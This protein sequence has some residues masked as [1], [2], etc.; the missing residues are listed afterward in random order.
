MSNPTSMRRTRIALTLIVLVLVGLG[1]RRMLSDAAHDDDADAHSGPPH[2]TIGPDLG[3]A[4]GAAKK[5]RSGKIGIA[6]DDAD[7]TVAITGQVIDVIDHTPVPN[8]EVVFKSSVGESSGTTGPDGKYKVAVAPGPYRA[9]VRDDSVLSVGTPERVRLPGFPSADV[10]GVPDEAL[11]PLV[12]AIAD[13]DNIDLSVTRG[14]GISGT[15]TDVAGHPIEG[16]VLRA[17]GGAGL[18]PALG[19]DLA[20][21][22]AKGAFEMRLPA[23][24]YLIDATHAKYAGATASSRI[25]VVVGGHAST[26]VVVTAGCVISGK[27]RRRDG[28]AAG[29]GAIEKQWGS[30]DLEFG[31][32]GRIEADGSFRWVTT[33]EEQVTLRAWPWK[34]PPSNIKSFAC[35]DG[36]RFDDVAFE[37]PDRGA[38][39]E[40]TLVDHDGN[41]VPFAFVD[42]APLD[43]GIGQQ[44]RTDAQ[45]R[46]AVYAMPAGSYRVTATAIGAGVVEQTVASP[47][48][49]VALRLSGLGTLEGTTSTLAN[50]SF[51]L[52]LDACGDALRLPNQSRIVQVVAGRY[53]VDDV[54]ACELTVSAT[55]HG[56]KTVGAATVPA[57]SSA[58]L[59]LS[60]GPPHDKT[61]QGVVKDIEGKPIAGTV[62]T[63]TL[64]DATT[65]ATTDDRGAFTLK[66]FSGA[67]IFAASGDRMANATVG[68][69]NVDREVVDLVLD[70]EVDM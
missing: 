20:E 32:A 12:V 10:A 64:D 42:L 39:I 36:A 6:I 26:H 46:W 16:V 43:N 59:E 41:P 30:T 57:G 61:V 5:L 63:A 7:G 70:Q 52:S 17:R 60:L 56:H 67:M 25:H 55:W 15:V 49:G 65:T 38:D 3:E 21:S 35:K 2:R 66:T 8:V 33:L 1:L 45:G 50:G 40:G 14:G 62:V 24:D 47:S 51:E 31:P 19:T 37:L 68:F 9:F 44:E 23:G 34:S 54:P 13:L 48:H 4:L 18:R 53:R 11:M 27:V 28:S 22:D 69:A 58:T 29:D